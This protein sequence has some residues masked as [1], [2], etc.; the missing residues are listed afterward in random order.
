M[1]LPYLTREVYW[2]KDYALE[3]CHVA[4][5]QAAQM[6]GH[7][8][9]TKSVCALHAS[10]TN[11]K[12]TNGTEHMFTSLTCI[13]LASCGPGSKTDRATSHREQQIPRRP[14]ARQTA[15]AARPAGLP[16]PLHMRTGSACCLAR[17]SQRLQSRSPTGINQPHIVL[18]P[19][20]QQTGT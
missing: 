13:V 3:C 14:S 9:F 2:G 12:H 15:P 4:C 18:A 8:L 20:R 19:H 11:L 6:V 7:K 1:E 10:I 5:C 16:Q 17:C